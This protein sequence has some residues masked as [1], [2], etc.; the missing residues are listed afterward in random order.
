VSLGRRLA[1]SWTADEVA[2]LVGAIV[3]GDGEHAILGVADLAAAG[4]DELAFCTGGRWERVLS[5][6]AAG[7]VLLADGDVP[8]GTVALRVQHPR[9]AFARALAALVPLARPAPG[10]HPT[11]VVDATAS[12]DGATIDAYAVVDAGAVVG[13]GTWVQAHAYV[14]PGARIGRD[15]RVGP[16]AV[17]LE[18]SRIGDRVWLHPGSVVGADGF[19]HVPTAD[20]PLRVPHLGHVLIEDDVEIG[21][22]ACVDRAALGHTRI[23]RGSRL[24]NLVQVAHGVDMGE[25]CLLAAFAGVAGGARLGDGVIMGGRAAVVD[26]IEVGDGAVFAGLASASKDVPAGRK[27]GGSPARRYREWLREFAALRELPSA[28]RTLHRLER[29]LEALEAADAEE[30]P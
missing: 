15:G 10:V 1:R 24:D 22:N 13:Q 21:A 16:H 23:G 25:A 18:G 29:R 4:P 11:A 9:L 17:V 5:D 20:G 3:E 6:T 2:R 7:V 26:G 27:L 28:L 30:E 12:V 8:D 14:G 19:G